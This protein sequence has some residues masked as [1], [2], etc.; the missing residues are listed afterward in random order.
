MILLDL[1]GVCAN[2]C[3]ASFTAHG[4]PFAEPTHWNYFE[5]W[6]VNVD[7]FWQPIHDLGEKFYGELVQPYSWLDR[8]VTLVRQHDEFAIV[9]TPS[10]SPW[11]Y[12]GKRVWVNKYI[13]EDVEVEVVTNKTLMSKPGNL[14]IDDCDLNVWRFRDS[15][16]HGDAVTFPQPWNEARV[17]MFARFGYLAEELEDWSCNIT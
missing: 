17:L 16:T 10:K 11:C 8:L 3:E 4:R 7:E 6:G 14:L 9:T 2:F 12:Y 15:A 5:D 13:G 1:D